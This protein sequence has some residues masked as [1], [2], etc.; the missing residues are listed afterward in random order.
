MAFIIIGAW[1]ALLAVLVKVGV[2]KG[3]ALWMKLSP[4]AIYA[5][6]FLVIAIPMN[7]TAPSGAVMV[8]RDSVSINPAVTGPV[9]K[10]MVKSGTVMEPGTPL[11]QIDPAP[12]EAT[13]ASLEAKLALSNTRLAQAKELMAKQA[14]RE[15]DVQTYEAEVAQLFCRKGPRS[16]E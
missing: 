13:L 12:Y 2:L 8:L 1:L 14:G 11:F 10:V 9:T 3:W 6:Y 16:D 7:F 4:I 15:F 5:L